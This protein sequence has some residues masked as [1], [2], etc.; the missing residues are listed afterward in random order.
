MCKTG[1]CWT[2]RS[3][4]VFYWVH[5]GKHVPY[6][7][8]RCKTGRDN[9]SVLGKT[10]PRRWSLL[11]GMTGRHHWAVQGSVSSFILNIMRCAWLLKTAIRFIYDGITGRSCILSGITGRLC[12][13]DGITGRRCSQGGIAGRKSV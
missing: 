10:A 8:H 1:R 13:Q 7:I 2:P 12:S 9:W 3:E 5:L 11:R 6:W 4:T